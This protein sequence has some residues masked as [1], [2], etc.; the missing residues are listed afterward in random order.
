MPVVRSVI[1]IFKDKD[2]DDADADDDELYNSVS[3]GQCSV[4]SLG[5]LD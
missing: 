4:I 5:R 1:H 2:G 3:A